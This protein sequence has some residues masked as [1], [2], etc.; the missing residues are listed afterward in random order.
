MPTNP[1]AVAWHF[2]E[3]V[4]APKHQIVTQQV[5]NMVKNTAMGDQIVEAG[6][7]F[8]PAIN[9]VA[10]LPCRQGLI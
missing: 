2:G 7:L 3:I 5:L 4:R 1:L 6:A 10:A 9:A 8:V